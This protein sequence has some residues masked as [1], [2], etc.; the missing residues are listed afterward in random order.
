VYSFPNAD[1]AVTLHRPG[2]HTPCQTPGC[3][4]VSVPSPYN[5]GKGVSQEKS[6]LR[7]NS[8]TCH[9]PFKLYALFHR[10]NEVEIIYIAFHHFERNYME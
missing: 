1:R 8:D 6:R 5:R 2:A 10:T 7:L 9:L 4:F 3:S